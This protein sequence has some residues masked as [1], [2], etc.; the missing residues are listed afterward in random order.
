MEVVFFWLS[1]YNNIYSQGLNFGSEYHYEVTES[2]NEIRLHRNKNEVF[3]RNFFHKTSNKEI[4]NITALVGENGSGKSNFLDALKKVLSG[5]DIHTG[6]ILVF[7][8]NDN[9]VFVV[10]DSLNMR[11]NIT[12]KEGESQ[13]CSYETIFYS[14]H[15]DLNIFPITHDNNPWVDVSTDWLVFKNFEVDQYAKKEIPQIEIFKSSEIRRQVNY[16]ENSNI[17]S[18]INDKISI[19]S[20]LSVT[21]I[22][23]DFPYRIKESKIR[24]IPYAYRKYYNYLQEAG[25]KTITYYT[26]NEGKNHFNFT[27]NEWVRKKCYAT[28]LIHFLKNFFYHLEKNNDYLTEGIVN[29]DLENLKEIDFEDAVI[30]FISNENLISDKNVVL[31]FISHIQELISNSEVKFDKITSVQWSIN[32]NEVSRLI[33]L[34]QM[35]LSSISHLSSSTANA[36]LDYSWRGLSTGEKAYLNLYSRIYYAREIISNKI[37][38]PKNSFESPSKCPTIIYLIIDEGELGFH[39][40]WQ[41]EYINNLIDF[42]PTILTFEVNGTTKRPKIQIIFST[43]SPISLSD[44]PNSHINYIQ[45]ASDGKAQVLKKDKKPHKSFGA[46]IHTLFVDSFFLHEG[47]VGEFAVYKINNLIEQIH[48]IESSEDLSSSRKLIKVID[49]PIIKEKLRQMLQKRDKE[50]SE[51]DRLEKQKALIEERIKKLRN[52]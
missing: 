51:L 29:I 46:N 12:F 39:A 1:E 11:L 3:V 15:L 17:E 7:L 20:F 16:L 10:S 13:G 47:L 35:Y 30:K 27:S 50:T 19:P 33:I 37:N 32:R 14:P 23:I 31:N 18:S 22:G 9:E 41:R 42:I 8:N 49:E 5:R 40:K 48:N 45:R 28:F 21:S 38:R 4:V 36:F 52:E 6:I 26:Q 43:H 24:N 44:I 2:N 25:S 34:E